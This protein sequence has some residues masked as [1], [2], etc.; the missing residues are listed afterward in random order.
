MLKQNIRIGYLL[1]A[2]A[3]LEKRFPYFKVS[4]RRGMFW[5]YLE[6]NNQSW[7]PVPDDNPIPNQGSDKQNRNRQLFRILVKNNHVSVEF[8]HILTDGYGA[9]IF[10]IT[11]LKYYFEEQGT[12]IGDGDCIP[13]DSAMIDEEFEDAY[14]RYFAVNIPPI[15]KYSKAFHLPFLRYSKPHFNVLTALVSLDDI[16]TASRKRKVSI[17]D[18]LTAVYLLVLQDIY[19][20]L[21]KHSWFKKR[22]IL[23]IQVPVNLRNIYSSVTMRN[24]SLFVLPEIDL[25]LG[26]YTFD[27][28][29][30]IVYHKMQM[31]TDK[32]F[33]N[34]IISRNVGSER[35]LFVRGIPLFIKSLI[36]RYK[37][38]SVGANQYSGVI[39]NL[40][41]VDLPPEMMERIGSFKF[42]PPPPNKKL[43]VNCGIIGI[44]ENLV[45]SFGNITSS[46]ELEKRFFK[47]L[48]SEGIHVKLTQ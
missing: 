15:V 5:Y 35:K 39:T 31:E 23:R 17:T 9:Y 30:K 37:Y 25:R 18:Y 10:L 12:V 43:K 32:K 16:K 45:I 6:C 33:I 40:G 13:S 8:S 41:K 29:I 34:K 46:N 22:K 20:D 1:K 24:F 14:N 19:N 27:E 38:Y 11:L 7:I 21:P 44:K 2:I 28:I 47:F 3:S 36:L 48:V 26:Q 4:L 42:I